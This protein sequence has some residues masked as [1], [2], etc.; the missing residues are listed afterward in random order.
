MYYGSVMK[1]MKKKII[2]ISVIIVLLFSSLL[3]M[4]TT[5]CCD[6]YGTD[7]IPDFLKEFLEHFTGSP[8]NPCRPCGDDDDDDTGD[9]D[10][11]TSSSS[12]RSIFTIK[13]EPV[14]TP[15]NKDPIAD[16]SGGEPYEGFINEEITFNGSSSY[17]PDGEIVEWFWDFG[18]GTTETG[19]IV[20][21]S[22][23]DPDTY[24]VELMVTDDDGAEDWYGTKIVISH[25][26]RPPTDP[27]VNY[28][29]SPSITNTKY[30]FKVMSTDP[31]GDNIRYI[32]DWGDGS[33]DETDYLPDGAEATLNH[34]WSLSGNYIVNISAVDENNASSGITTLKVKIVDEP[35]EKP[36]FFVWWL[37]L[38]AILIAGLILAAV[39][40]RKKEKKSEEE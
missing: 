1:K 28:S 7:D 21:H 32:V 27:V 16:A 20:K 38:L 14:I 30:I 33:Y 18:D 29:I 23:P 35:D 8:C 25:P 22:Y 5:A 3:S 37:L 34:T 17:D 40:S 10:D 6:N 13:K 15:P 31:D 12:G 11:D 24:F 2:S 19:A 9:D 39:Y 26:N 4:T 36:Y